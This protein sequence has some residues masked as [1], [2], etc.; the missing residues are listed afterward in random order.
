MHFIIYGLTIM[1]NSQDTILSPDPVEL[2]ER[3]VTLDSPDAHF[4][5]LGKIQGAATISYEL[6][7]NLRKRISGIIKDDLLVDGE[8]TLYL[9]NGRILKKSGLFN[10]DEDL[11]TGEITD[12][13]YGNR[14][15]IKRGNFVND[16]LTGRGIVESIFTESEGEERLCRK[17]FQN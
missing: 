10:K 8:T 11:I 1:Q 17:N 5:S 14:T 12:C 13:R 2:F 16:K 15:D 4:D 3:M 9:E 7:G 6:E